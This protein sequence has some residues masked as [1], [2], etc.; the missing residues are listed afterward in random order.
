MKKD[1]NSHSYL[2]HTR[3]AVAFT[4]EVIHSSVSDSDKNSSF[5]N[6]SN[7]ARTCEFCIVIEIFKM[8]CEPPKWGP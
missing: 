1:H 5:P 4:A 7:N 8:W 6:D 3:S 2:T